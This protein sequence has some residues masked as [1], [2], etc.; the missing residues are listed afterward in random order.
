MVENLIYFALGR[1]SVTHEP[2]YRAVYCTYTQTKDE[3]G[4][5]LPSAVRAGLTYA[6]EN[7]IANW[8]VDV[9]DEVDS[10]S[11]KD[12]EWENSD[13]FRCLF[14]ESSIRNV[15]FV[16]PPPDADVDLGSEKEWAAGFAAELG[17]DFSGSAV[18]SREQI[19]QYFR[20]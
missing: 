10:M 5:F 20:R 4:V 6:T 3:F 7:G 17:K 19:A 18:D 15:L 11:D 16:L 2:N 1:I 14:R 12:R 9:V 13:E 8:V